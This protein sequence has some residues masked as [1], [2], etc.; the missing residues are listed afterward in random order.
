MTEYGT[1]SMNQK[2]TDKCTSMQRWRYNDDE[3]LIFWNKKL[4]NVVESD[5][6][7]FFSDNLW[8]EWSK[9]HYWLLYQIGFYD[10]INNK[11]KYMDIIMVNFFKQFKLI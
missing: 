2:Y 8:S 6:E 4:Y 3:S 10:P 1:F 7:N 9:L 11:I 5:F